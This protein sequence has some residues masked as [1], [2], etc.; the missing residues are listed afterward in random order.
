MSAASLEG[1][2]TA[3]FVGERT[4]FDQFPVMC[5]LCYVFVYLP[6][7]LFFPHRTLEIGRYMFKRWEWADLHGRSICTTRELARSMCAGNPRMFV[8]EEPVNQ[9]LPRETVEFGQHTFP[10]SPGRGLYDKR[11]LR[12]VAV[13]REVISEAE[14]ELRRT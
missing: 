3:I 6:S 12:M 8:I 10:A 5:R 2:E 13:P 9:C 11:K 4:T 1:L 7:I 14:N